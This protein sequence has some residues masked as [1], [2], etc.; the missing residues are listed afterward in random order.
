M[1]PYLFEIRAVDRAGHLVF[2]GAAQ[3][4]FGKLLQFAT[5]KVRFDK[6]AVLQRSSDSGTCALIQV[7]PSR[8]LGEAQK[9][10]IAI[11]PARRTA[12]LAKIQGQI[13]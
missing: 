4:D 11:N 1:K 6:N 12:D 8:V 5:S 3:K 9:F 2:V 10:A 7:S 13:R